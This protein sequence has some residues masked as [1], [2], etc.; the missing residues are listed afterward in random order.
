MIPISVKSTASYAYN[1]PYTAIYVDVTVAYQ[2]RIKPTSHK[3]WWLCCSITF[4]GS[5]QMNYMYIV[6]HTPNCSLCNFFNTDVWIIIGCYNWS[7][8]IYIE[9]EV[10]GARLLKKI[11]LQAKSTKW[12]NFCSTCKNELYHLTFLANLERIFLLCR[13]VGS[14][15]SAFWQQVCPNYAQKFKK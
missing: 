10:L 5:I 1:I 3:P 4:T 9:T 6:F 7:T 14:I 8:E 12:T 13:P 15:I 11:G 2:T